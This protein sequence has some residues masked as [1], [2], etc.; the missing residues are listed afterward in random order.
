MAGNSSN[1]CDF[2]RMAT[3]AGRRD[4]ES[5]FEKTGLTFFVAVPSCLKAS[6]RGEKMQNLY[7]ETI[8]QW[9]NA[10]I[11]MLDSGHP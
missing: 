3:R 11:I 2:V 9:A 7:K 8:R 10:V 6:R 1:F 5:V 4:I